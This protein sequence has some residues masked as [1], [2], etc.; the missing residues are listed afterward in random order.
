MIINAHVSQLSV[1]AVAN[2]QYGPTDPRVDIPSFSDP[3]LS[4]CT[5][6]IRASRKNRMALVDPERTNE[7]NSK[8]DH[9]DATGG[10]GAR[11]SLD[12]LVV[13]KAA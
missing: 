6:S 4:Y 5:F 2:Q 3:N 8:D 13:P 7:K 10:G 11:P 9:N 12:L 1:I